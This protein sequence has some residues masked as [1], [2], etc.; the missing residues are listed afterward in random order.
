MYVTLFVSYI[1]RSI[2]V[3]AANNARSTTKAQLKGDGWRRRRWPAFGHPGAF[4]SRPGRT[5][6]RPNV[7]HARAKTQ[8]W[9]LHRV[10]TKIWPLKCLMSPVNMSW[11]LFT[12]GITYWFDSKL[13]LKGILIRKC[14]DCVGQLDTLTLRGPSRC[15]QSIPELSV[16]EWRRP[17]PR[18]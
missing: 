1:W 11:T 9:L 12:H 7:H 13:T 15:H 10:H 4:L 17:W 2:N 3:L 18:D 14:C 6:H 8:G 16:A 5:A